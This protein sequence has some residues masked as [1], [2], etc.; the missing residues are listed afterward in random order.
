MVNAWFWL[1]IILIALNWL[2]TW[3]EW[4]FVNWATKPGVIAAM[5]VWYASICGCQLPAMWF[6]LGL[7]FSLAGDL[8]LMLPNRFFLVGTMAFMLAHAAYIL[9]FNQPLPDF[10][11]SMLSLFAVFLSLMV[12]IYA[13]LRRG[14]KSSPAF[15]RLVK[16]L[17]IY[18]LMISLM[19]LSALTTL[20]RP[21]W[22][23]TASGLV[24]SGAILF[25]FSD[26]LLAAD[27][28]VKAIPPARLWKRV[29][30]QL[31]QLALISGAM[32]QFSAN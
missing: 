18:S 24:V 14:A 17:A 16:P 12:I 27:R 20:F 1:T 21:D 4:R 29:A 6:G 23:P 8:L 9:G 3:F 7:L 2:S 15:R 22:Q 10:T 11:L 28:F 19:V 26:I 30:Y 32:V 13:A 25:L 5:L 31:G